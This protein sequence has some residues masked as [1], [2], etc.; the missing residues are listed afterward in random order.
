MDCMLVRAPKRGQIILIEL[1]TFQIILTTA[2]GS[3]GVGLGVEAG[4]EIFNYLKGGLKHGT[5]IYRRRWKNKM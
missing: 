5:N 3:V 1:N 4:R 2:I